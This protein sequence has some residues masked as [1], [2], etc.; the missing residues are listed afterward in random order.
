MNTLGLL[1][2]EAF[3]KKHMMMPLITVTKKEVK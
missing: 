2:V 1:G 3:L